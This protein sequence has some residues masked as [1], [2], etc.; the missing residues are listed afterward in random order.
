MFVFPV[1]Q[2]GSIEQESQAINDHKAREQMHKIAMPK[3][4]PTISAFT[5]RSRRPT[6]YSATCIV[7]QVGIKVYNA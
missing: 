7:K 2:G 4:E 5:G 6:F 1:G 3:L